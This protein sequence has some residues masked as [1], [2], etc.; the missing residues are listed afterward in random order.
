MNA[1][2]EFVAGLHIHSRCA[3]AWSKNRTLPNLAAA[4]FA[5]Y[6]GY[7]YWKSRKPVW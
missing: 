6:G 4:A 5:A 7:R 2:Q 3:Y 1:Q